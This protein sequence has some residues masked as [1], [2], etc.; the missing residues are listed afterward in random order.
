M[1][2]PT[3]PTMKRRTKSV[4]AALAIAGVLTALL[5][6]SVATAD[7]RPANHKQAVRAAKE[8]LQSQ[9]FSLKGLIGQLRYEGYSKN[10]ATYGA[11]H[12]GANWMKQAVK[13]AKQYLRMEA[14]SLSGLVAQLQYEGFTH[15]QA[16]H[17]AR[18]AGL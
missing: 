5:F 6:G 12:S 4:M 13:S 10:D 15:A 1:N 17:G 18:A 16:V 3:K 9:A 8:Y 14:F 7:A 2:K 11:K